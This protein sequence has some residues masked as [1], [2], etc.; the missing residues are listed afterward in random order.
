MSRLADNAVDFFE[1]CFTG[2]NSLRIPSCNMVRMPLRM[3]A[4]S[5]YPEYWTVCHFPNSVSDF[6]GHHELFAQR[7]F[8]LCN[9]RFSGELPGLKQL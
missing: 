7:N 8:V 9:Y 1:G 2:D 6:A 3:A 5:G 4:A